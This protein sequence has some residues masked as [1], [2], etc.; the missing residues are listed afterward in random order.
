MTASFTVNTGDRDCCGLFIITFGSLMSR[1][2]PSLKTVVG[3]IKDNGV[4]NMRLR[5]TVMDVFSINVKYSVR[6][7]L[8]LMS[9]YLHE[10]KPQV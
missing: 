6:I 5:V 10:S 3:L 8:V 1:G 9:Y 4:Y 7:I 2:N